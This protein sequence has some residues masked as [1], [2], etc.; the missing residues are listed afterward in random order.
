MRGGGAAGVCGR[1]ALPCSQASQ[2]GLVV[3]PAKGVGARRRLGRGPGGS[4]VVGHPGAGSL[5]HI[6]WSMR[7]S[8]T[9]ATSIN[10]EKKRWETMATPPYA[11]REMGVLYPV[12]RWWELAAD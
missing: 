9:R 5:G 12:F 8:H 4:G 10:W 7:H 11:G 6:Q 1:G 2:C 3:R